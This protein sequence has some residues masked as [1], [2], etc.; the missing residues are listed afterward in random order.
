MYDKIKK[1]VEKAINN[2]IKEGITD[3]DL[4]LR[5]FEIDLIA[6]SDNKEAVKDETARFIDNALNNDPKSCIENLKINQ[7]GRV[8]VPKKGGYDFRKCALID[9]LDEIKYLA[10]VLLIANKIE[11]KRLSVKSN[12]IFS[13]RYVASDNNGWLF[14]RK[15]GMNA[16]RKCNF[17]MSRNKDFNVMVECDIANF[18]DRLNLHRLES[19]L[20][21]AVAKDDNDC[22]VIRIINSL[23]LYWSNRDSYGLPVGSNAS[24]I[25]AEAS[26]IDVDKYLFDNGVPFTRFV[27]DFRI[28]AKTSAEAYKYL[29]MLIKRL[30]QEG[31]FLNSSKT[32]IKDM[33]ELI[34]ETVDENSEIQVDEKTEDEKKIIRGY[35]GLVPT[36]FTRLRESEI[37]K[38]KDTNIDKFINVL[39]EKVVIDEKDEEIKTCIKAIVAQ[40]KYE[41]I[42]DLPN[43]LHKNPQFIPYFIDMIMKNYDHINKEIIDNVKIEFSKWFNEEQVPEYILVYLVRIFDSTKLKDKKV[44]FDYFRKLPRNSGDYIGRALLESIQ[45]NLNRSEILEIREYYKRADNWEKHQILNIIANGLSIDEAKAFFRNID[46]KNDLITTFIKKKLL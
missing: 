12:H 41:F 6:I 36:K 38:Y 43:I 13:Y 3:V 40:S 39:K 15:I 33:S 32:K 10:L 9:V 4:F 7:I 2:V 29:S 20:L 23:L 17:Q 31:L 34:D 28:Y 8:L 44:L 30:S 16:F 19:T 45:Q 46:N 35:A 42:T 25:L 24:R 37:Y 11:K 21:S 14:N 18:Y 26:L 27:D 22:K 1:S 5:P